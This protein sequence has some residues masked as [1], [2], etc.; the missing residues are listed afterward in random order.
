LYIDKGDNPPLGI[1]V[2]DNT[3]KVVVS[4]TTTGQITTVELGH[5]APGVYIVKLVSAHRTGMYKIV[6]K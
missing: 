3:G 6:K 2:L 5:L 1:E 4:Q